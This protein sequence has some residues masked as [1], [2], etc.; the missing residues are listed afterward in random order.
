MILL[1][2]RGGLGGGDGCHFLF[3]SSFL[4]SLLFRDSSLL[5]Y[6]RGIDDEQVA[7][8]LLVPTT[9]LASPCDAAP[10]L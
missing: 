9:L 2:P 3:S 4:S 8:W 5:D 6:A 10:P 7:L 1:G